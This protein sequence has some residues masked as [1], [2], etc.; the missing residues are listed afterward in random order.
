MKKN[1]EAF[2]VMLGDSTMEQYQIETVIKQI[3]DFL[4][5]PNRVKPFIDTSKI[6]GN[7]EWENIPFTQTR[8]VPWISDDL[9]VQPSLSEELRMFS[10]YVSVC[11]YSLTLV[12]P[13]NFFFMQFIL[14]S[15]H[16]D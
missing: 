16:T 3:E 4:P 14:S 11:I 5:C 8:Y 9:K 7:R 1:S 12:L 13:P 10:A 6:R 2:N 15:A